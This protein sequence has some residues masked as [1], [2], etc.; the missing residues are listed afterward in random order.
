M[1]RRTL[2]D[3]GSSSTRPPRASLGEPEKELMT[4]PRFEQ[5]HR[6]TSATRPRAAHGSSRCAPAWPGDLDQADKDLSLDG[7]LRFLERLMSSFG[8]SIDDFV[9]RKNVAS[10]GAQRKRAVLVV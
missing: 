3:E 8:H 7:R 1:I 4:S 5:C 2:P 10:F 9:S 6:V